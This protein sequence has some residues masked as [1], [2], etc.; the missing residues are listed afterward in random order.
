MSRRFDYAFAFECRE[1][2]PSNLQTAQQRTL[3]FPRDERQKHGLRTRQET[4]VKCTA[5]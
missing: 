2:L 5:C 3:P 4:L 1:E